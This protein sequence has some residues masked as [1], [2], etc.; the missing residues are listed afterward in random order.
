MRLLTG[1]DNLFHIYIHIIYSIYVYIYLYMYA[2]CYIALDKLDKLELKSCSLSSA[3]YL[4]LSAC[5]FLQLCNYRFFFF[6]LLFCLLSLFSLCFP[7][8]LSAAAAVVFPVSY[9][10]TCVCVCV[11]PCVLSDCVC[12][13]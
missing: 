4:L 5:C 7:L 13:M 9:C 2:F 8:V 1:Y 11:C 12:V 6:F 10:V 3:L